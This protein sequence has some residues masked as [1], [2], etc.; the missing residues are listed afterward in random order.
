MLWHRLAM[1]LGGTVEELQ[2]RMSSAEFTYWLAFYEKE[3]WGFE[4][5][6]FHAGVIASTVVNMAPRKKGASPLKP[7]DFYPVIEKRKPQQQTRLQRQL[8]ERRK[9]KKRK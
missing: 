8:A 2:E 7:S 1:R 4:M 3:P 6:N 5:E 9:R